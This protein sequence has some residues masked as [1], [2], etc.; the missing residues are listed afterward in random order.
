DKAYFADLL[1]ELRSAFMES[2]QKFRQQ[3]G[4]EAG[5][6]VE[7]FNAGKPP[8]GFNAG[9]S[10][11]EEAPRPFFMDPRMIARY[12]GGKMPPGYPGAAPASDSEESAAAK[13]KAASASGLTNQIDLI[14]L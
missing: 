13:P 6:W 4:I 12:F 3:K 11:E 2:E 10:T 9:S 5:V 7:K 14:N 1:G 8:E